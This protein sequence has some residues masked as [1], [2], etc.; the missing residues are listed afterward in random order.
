MKLVST[1]SNPVPERAV[2]GTLKTSDG[3]L[4]RFARFDPPPGR[5]GTLCLFPGRSEF[6]EKYFEVVREAQARGLAVAMLDWRG[7]GLSERLLR[8]PLRGHIKKFSQYDTDIEAFMREVVLP[9]CPPPIFAV[10]H[11]MGAAIL[12]RATHRGRRWFD[13]VIL[14]AP[15]I[16]LPWPRLPSLAKAATKILYATGF[17]HSY[18]PSTGGAKPVTSYPFLGNTLTSDPVRYA[19]TAEIV[20]AEPALALASPTVG[21]LHAATKAM[22]EFADPAY[23]KKIR[24]PMLFIAAGQDQVVS[25]AATEQFAVRLRSGMHL[26]IPRARHELLMEQDT[27]R[28]QFWAAFDAFV[29]G[30]PVFA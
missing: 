28:Q 6:I 25:T 1:P 10:A 12:I 15:M 11:S 5:K 27:Y 19:R 30:S 20:E 23:A 22:N 2:V 3:V 18:V 4:L 21:W 13:R 7:Q 24:Q 29:P 17:R 16:D 8:D 9:D 26:M 14:S